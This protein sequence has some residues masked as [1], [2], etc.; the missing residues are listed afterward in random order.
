M[1]LYFVLIGIPLAQRWGEKS[2]LAGECAAVGAFDTAMRLLNR[3]IGAANFEPLK[4][5]MLELYMASHAY[6][7]G[8][9]SVTA[10]PI[11]APLGR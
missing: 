7:P 2:S 5:H 11:L 6:V 3:Q 1:L 4:T 9:P 10:S 8:V